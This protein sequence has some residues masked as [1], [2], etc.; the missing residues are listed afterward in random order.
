LPTKTSTSGVDILGEG[1]V[2]PK[3]KQKSAQNRIKSL[4]LDYKSGISAGAST[5]IEGRKRW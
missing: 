1:L 4:Q 2:F 3:Y 5:V